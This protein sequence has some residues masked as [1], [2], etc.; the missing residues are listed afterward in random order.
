MRFFTW[1]FSI[2]L[3]LFSY[4][5]ATDAPGSGMWL[6]TA[7]TAALLAGTLL[8]NRKVNGGWFRELPNNNNKAGK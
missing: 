1:F 3:A 7:I 2:M 8:Y 5:W 4:F 6:P